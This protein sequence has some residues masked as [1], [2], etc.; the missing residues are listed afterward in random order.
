MTKKIQTTNFI[1]YEELI[2]IIKTRTITQLPALLK[3]IVE[4]NIRR[5]VW[6][7]GG[8]EHFIENIIKNKT[9]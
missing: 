6:Q 2:K 9:N 8:M 1:E 4:E 3:L 5:K 7:P